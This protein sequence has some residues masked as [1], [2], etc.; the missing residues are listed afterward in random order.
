MWKWDCNMCKDHHP[1]Q[2]AN[3]VFITSIVSGLSSSKRRVQSFCRMC[4][5]N[6]YLLLLQVQDTPTT[7]HQPTEQSPLSSIRKTSNDKCS[8]E[9]VCSLCNSHLLSSTEYVCRALRTMRFLAKIVD[10][11]QDE[12]VLQFYL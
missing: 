5:N 9:F 3:T 11:M 10:C 7:T 12:S 6:Q 4:Q 1:P 2:E 8:L